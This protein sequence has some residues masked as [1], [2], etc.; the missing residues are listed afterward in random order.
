MPES[1][2]SVGFSE[3]EE[4][5][6]KLP[7]E[8]GRRLAQKQTRI[9]GLASEDPFVVLEAMSGGNLGPQNALV[10]NAKSFSRFFACASGPR[11]DGIALLAE[12]E[13]TVIQPGSVIAF[14]A[15]VYDVQAIDQRLRSTIHCVAIVGAGMDRTLL[16]FGSL[17]PREK[18]DRLEIRDCTIQSSCDV[19][20]LNVAGLWRA[21]RVR[22]I[23]FDCGAG[24]SCAFSMMGGAMLELK[25]CL[26]EGGYGRSPMHGNLFDAR[27]HP[28][29][30]RFEDC[31]V[32]SLEADLDGLPMGSTLVLVRCKFHDL[33]DRALPMDRTDDGLVLN[34]TT[35][36]LRPK[37]A[38]K[39]E[40][41]DVAEL[42]PA[43]VQPSKR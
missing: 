4:R 15:G 30:A 33:F 10:E 6:R 1:L 13:P 11:I 7:R 39:V 23:G 40:K 41:R 8:I 34:A 22:F 25:S 21:E 38:G 27:S 36:E 18:L 19:V 17:Q 24:G 31:T 43:W 9:E 32:H 16:R 42:F 20:D 35:L 37:D 28:I 3:F 14:P 12:K 2:L 29:L 5:V 26:I